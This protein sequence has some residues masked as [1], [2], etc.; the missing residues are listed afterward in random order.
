MNAELQNL[1]DRVALLERHVAALLQE[2]EKK[3]RHPGRTSWLASEIVKL[4][5]ANEGM[6]MKELFGRSRRLS[7]ARA[8]F[9]AMYLIHRFTDLCASDIART[10]SG[11]GHEMVAYAVKQVKA[12]RD[13]EPDF[14]KRL[15]GYVAVLEGATPSES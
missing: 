5:G 1:K 10:F 8:R 6:P 13:T 7:T 12:R 9:V 2:R 3:A 15:A 14:A 11:R 4:V